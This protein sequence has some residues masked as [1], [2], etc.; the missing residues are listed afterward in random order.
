MKVKN[1][2]DLETGEVIENAKIAEAGDKIITEGQ[3]NAF[4]KI[5]KEK[6][7]RSNQPNFVFAIYKS[8]EPYLENEKLKPQDVSRLIMLA[9]YTRYDGRLMK[10]EQTSMSK[11][12]MQKI[13]RI[14]KIS[15]FNDFHNKLIHLGILVNEPDVY[16]MNSNYFFK[17]EMKS[18]IST[19]KLY[20]N[21]IRYIFNSALT[22]TIK[23][24]GYVFML[25]PYVNYEHNIVCHNPTERD[26]ANIK[27]MSLG[28]LADL[29]KMTD[30]GFSKFLTNIK[31][32]EL[33]NKT[34]LTFVGTCTDKR[35]S[36]IIINPDV[37]YAGKLSHEGLSTLKGLF[38]STKV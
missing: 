25:L 16:F 18:G 5:S 10:T 27:P 15:A 11:K 29:L 21:E 22:S 17:G 30:V 37:M 13:V 7:S 14:K 2:V 38:K 34:Y 20:C 4:K 12:D 9:T 31:N 36:K 1:V 23:R 24:L 3:S 35:S 19:K 26:I 32:V 28:Y 33:K 8:C 6:K